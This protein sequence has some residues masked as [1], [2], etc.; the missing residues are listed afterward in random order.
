MID[1][2]PPLGGVYI[3]SEAPVPLPAQPAP[4]V[5]N[6]PLPDQDMLHDLSRKTLTLRFYSK[7]QE[8]KQYYKQWT[9]YYESPFQ[10][11]YGKQVIDNWY[12]DAAQRHGVSFMD[13]RRILQRTRDEL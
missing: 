12:V 11:S 3:D 5:P 4:V 2:A 10:L 7:N 13:S 6:V 8:K 1:V 9:I